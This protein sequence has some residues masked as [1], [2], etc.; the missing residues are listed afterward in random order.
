MLLAAGVVLVAV[1]IVV[2]GVLRSDGGSG[3]SGGPV[4]VTG[5]AVPTTSPSPGGSARGGASVA[6]VGSPVPFASASGGASVIVH[7]AGAVRHPGVVTLSSGARVETAIERAGGAEPDADLVRLNLARPVVDG[8]RIYVPAAG[9][10]ALPAVVDGSGAGGGHDGAA[11]GAGAGA[12]AGGGSPGAPVDLN[13]AD[14]A[15]LETL[16]GIGPAL[17]GRILTWRE[18]HGG[19]HQVEDLLE[20]SGIGDGRFAE[21]RDL[22]R[23]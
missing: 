16:P 8:E 15:A 12:G 10:T 1:G 23:V 18:E 5:A 6:G 4:T 19:F 9:E 2:V 13:T 7:V 21:L 20:V 14:Q 11:A 3:G 17:A 22:V